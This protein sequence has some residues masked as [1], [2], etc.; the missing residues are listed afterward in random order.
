MDR[1]LGMAQSTVS[2]GLRELMCLAGMQGRCFA[3]GADILWKLV[4]IRVGEELLRQ[5]VH[6]E[7]QCDQQMSSQEQLDPGWKASDNTVQS[8][9]GKQASRAYVSADGVMVPTTTQQSKDKRRQTDVKKRRAMPWHQ[10]IELKPLGAVG[11]ESDLGRWSRNVEQR[12]I[13]SKG[14][15]DAGIYPMPQA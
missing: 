9:D 5:T 6:K 8:P 7:G 13:A 14:R 11:K 15:E 10:R 2:V 4:G 3:R 12:R 1:L